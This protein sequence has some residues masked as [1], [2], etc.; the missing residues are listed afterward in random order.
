MSKM[1]DDMR[2][3]AVL[4]RDKEKIAMKLR[5]GWSPEQ[6]CDVDEYPMELIQEVQEE[7]LQPAQ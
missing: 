2:N 1:M 3:E 5:K 4:L 6:I 7:L